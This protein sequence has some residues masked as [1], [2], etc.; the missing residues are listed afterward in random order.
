MQAQH[1]VGVRDT[2]CGRL[3]QHDRAC[4]RLG[5]RRTRCHQVGGGIGQRQ[6]VGADRETG[7]AKQ[8]LRPGNRQ[9]RVGRQEYLRAPAVQ[10]RGRTRQRGEVRGGIG[11][12][13]THAVRRERRAQ[14]QQGGGLGGG[15]DGRDG[16]RDGARQRHSGRVGGIGDVG[17]VVANGNDIAVQAEMSGPDGRAN[18]RQRRCIGGCYGL[19]VRRLNGRSEGADQA[20]RTGQGADRVGHRQRRARPQRKAR[21]QGHRRQVCHAGRGIANQLRAGGHRLGQPHKGA[22]GR[23]GGGRPPEMQCDV[24]QLRLGTGED[25]RG[26]RDRQKSAAENLSRERRERRTGIGNRNAGGRGDQAG[27][28]R[29]RQNRT[30]Q[31]TA[32]GGGDYDRSVGFQCRENRTGGDQVL[33]G[34]GNQQRGRAAECH[35]RQG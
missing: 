2:Q 27:G 10:C 17:S 12:R 3:R 19:R 25:A 8:R 33:G 14:R 32:I 34:V 15:R 7:E 22:E 29:R 13:Q 24:E 28:L 18:A 11:D 5:C 31:G 26:H 6:A 9:C 23:R 21:Q 1:R 30:G 16:Q 4:H 20:R 35:Q